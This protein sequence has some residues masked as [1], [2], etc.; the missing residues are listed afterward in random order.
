V[1]QIKRGHMGPPPSRVC[2]LSPD[3]TSYRDRNDE[4]GLIFRRLGKLSTVLFYRY[5]ENC[6]PYDPGVMNFDG[7]FAFLAARGS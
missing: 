7:P 6:G 5:A 3:S 4:V 2:V 1:T